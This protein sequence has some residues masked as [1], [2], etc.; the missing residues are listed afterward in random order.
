[1]ISYWKVGH[2]IKNNFPFVVVSFECICQYLGYCLLG[3]FFVTSNFFYISFGGLNN[4]GGWGVMG[5]EF[6]WVLDENV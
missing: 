5:K 2:R 4:W 6:H 1:M 3:A